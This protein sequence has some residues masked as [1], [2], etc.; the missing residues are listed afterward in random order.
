MYLK[1]LPIPGWVCPYCN[2][3]NNLLVQAN[4][5]SLSTL[6]A[7][8]LYLINYYHLNAVIYTEYGLPNIICRKGHLNSVI[9]YML[10]V[11]YDH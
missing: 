3:T 9:L 8:F 10:L 11:F 6:P 1:L 5:S 7:S 4:T 2:Q